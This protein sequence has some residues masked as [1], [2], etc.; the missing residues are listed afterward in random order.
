MKKLLLTLTLAL[1]LSGLATASEKYQIDTRGMHAFVTFKVKHLG[2]SWLQG[3]FRK[4]SGSFEYDEQNPTNNKVSVEIDTASVDTNHAERD[5]HIKSDGFFNVK[6][7]PKATFV[8]KTWQDLGEGKAKLTGTLT[9]RGIS[10]DV[11]LDVT[12]IGAGKDPWG[13]YRRGFEAV[14]RIKMSDFNMK[15]AKMLGPV[16]DNVELWI[17]VEGVRQE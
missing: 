5:K 17:S 4:F 16:S 15:D 10:K 14:G 13:G 12:H 8:S 6:K 2:F 3:H 9:F 1:S 11:T 7:F